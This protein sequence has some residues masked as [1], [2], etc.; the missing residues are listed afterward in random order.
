MLS[1]FL[2]LIIIV[3]LTIAISTFFR[4]PPTNIFMVVLLGCSLVLYLFGIFGFMQIGYFFIV[5]M[6]LMGMVYCF[7]QYKKSL[8]CLFSVPMVLLY[9]MIFG[10]LLLNSSV[11]V[12]DSEVI[13]YW[14]PGLQHLLQNGTLPYSTSNVL[15]ADTLHPP[16]LWLLQYL[17]LYG[18][19][20]TNLNAVFAC[21]NLLAFACILPSF[22]DE[23]PNDR[24]DVLLILVNFILI[25]SLLGT[26]S[27]LSSISPGRLFAFLFG[28][29]IYIVITK[30][31]DKRFELTELSFI[32]SGVMLLNS[33]GFAFAFVILLVARVMA[34]FA[35]KGGLIKRVFSAAKEHFMA[36]VVLMITS[37]SFVL[38]LF[39]SGNTSPETALTSIFVALD[40]FLY[41][42]PYTLTV[43]SILILPNLTQ[44]TKIKF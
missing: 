4:L 39:L 44:R 34:F 16:L 13:T 10:S 6:A 29:G 37:S 11:S 15:P 35:T 31:C 24:Y 30:P 20:G 42:F 12:T 3:T 5:G 26:G 22:G 23:R 36:T 40:D 28:Y 8:S 33:T 27:G 7:I 14:L 32:L 25:Y 41:W 18:S 2:G 17:M 43:L 38:L 19:D 1:F 21:N 9:A